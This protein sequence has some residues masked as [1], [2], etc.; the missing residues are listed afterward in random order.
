METLS[1]IILFVVAIFWI[2]IIVAG[3]IPFFN[4]GLIGL[5]VIL[6][7]FL[8][9]FTGSRRNEEIIEEINENDFFDPN[10]EE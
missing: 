1:L 5:I 7:G 4:C 6:I 2:A 9:M 10:A 8:L 3:W